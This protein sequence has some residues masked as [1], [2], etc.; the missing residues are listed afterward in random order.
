MRGWIA[1]IAHDGCLRIWQNWFSRSDQEGGIE[2]WHE[3]EVGDALEHLLLLQTV[4]GAV[5]VVVAQNAEASVWQL[6]SGR[7]LGRHQWDVTI[8]QVL[9]CKSIAVLVVEASGGTI[10]AYSIQAR[11]VLTGELLGEV[12]PRFSRSGLRVCNAQQSGVRWIEVPAKAAARVM[13][14]DLQGTSCRQERELPMLAESQV[15]SLCIGEDFISG[16]L[17][18]DGCKVWTTLSNKDIGLHVTGPSGAT[19]SHN[20]QRLVVRTEEPDGGCL[21]SWRLEA[22]ESQEMQS[23][24]T[25]FIPAGEGWHVRDVVFDT[26][27]LV[28][29]VWDMAEQEDVL[30]KD[31]QATD[32]DPDTNHGFIAILDMTV[33]QHMHGQEYDFI[34]ELS[35]SFKMQ[36]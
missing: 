36:V 22:I 16:M 23:L 31:L 21:Y 20:D 10:S 26:A 29:A 11:N 33:K 27:R 30:D 35:G 3:V 5:A 17:P 15:M 7:C 9:A 19:H 25:C 12:G 14:W 28:I 4:Q 2:C 24:K 8:T 1:S 18:G 34:E 13:H 6:S 32:F